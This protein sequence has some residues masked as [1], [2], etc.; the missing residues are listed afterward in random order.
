MPKGPTVNLEV[1]DY[2]IEFFRWHPNTT[3]ELTQEILRNKYGESGIPIPSVRTI[4]KYKKIILEQLKNPQDKPWALAMMDKTGIP[5]EAANFLLKASI[6]LQEL[7]KK[8]EVVWPWT[9]ELL[10]ELKKSRMLLGMQKFQ[11]EVMT[12]REAKWLWRVH[13]A[14]PTVELRNILWRTD[15]YA[16]R[17]MTSDFLKREFDTSDL[18]GGLKNLL[19]NI[20]ER[21]ESSKTS[22]QEK[23]SIDEERGK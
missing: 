11:K 18:D 14:L 3:G 21:S 10:G 2:L 1:L 13:L 8:G 15:M 16:H 7:Q 9:S 19:R 22:K 12:N 20:R 23:E 5:W 6:T 4:Q 17:E